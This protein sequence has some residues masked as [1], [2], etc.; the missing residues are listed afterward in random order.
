VTALAAPRTL[1]ERLARASGRSLIGAAP[2]NE[3]PA[4]DGLQEPADVA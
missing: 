2:A 3:P 1:E 4:S